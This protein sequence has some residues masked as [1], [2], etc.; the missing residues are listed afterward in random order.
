MTDDWND[1]ADD[2][3]NSGDV[4]LYA[5][6]AFASLVSNIDLRAPIWKSKRVLD[7]GCGTGL[8]AEKVAPYVRELI[9]VDTSDKMIAVLKRKTLDKVT[10][11]CGDILDDGFR[12][13]VGPSGFDLIYASS[14]CSFL[15]D[16]EGTVVS[17]ARLLK[18]GGH[19]VQWDWL[20]S[21]DE[22]FGLTPSQ[23]RSALSNAQ[24]QSTRV[25]QAFMIGA[26]G[27]TLPVL[28]GVGVS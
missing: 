22:G 9:A 1:Y 25:E 4:K 6:R 26:D 18:P 10:A 14:V 8:L 21:G 27:T 17:L 19:F 12:L 3:D 20:A 7:F 24:L 16:F 13:G 5:D 28:I 2:W 15:P 11:L 23:I